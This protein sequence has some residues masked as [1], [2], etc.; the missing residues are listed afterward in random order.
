MPSALAYPMNS[1]KYNWGYHSDK[2]NYLNGRVLD[3]PRGKGLGGSSSINGMV[4]VRGHPDDFNQWEK[5]GA[6]GW[7]YSTC[8][9][10][11]LKAERWISGKDSYRSDNGNLHVCFGRNRNPLYKAFINSGI[12][13][14]YSYTSDY[15]GYKQEGFSQMQMTVKNGV[16]CSSYKAYIEGIVHRKNLKII[17]KTS[18]KELIIDDNKVTG[19]RVISK[20][21]FYEYFCSKEVIVSAGS[22]GSPTILQRSGIGDQKLLSELGVDLV[23]HLPGVGQNL[24]DHLEVYFQYKCKK[25]ITLNSKLNPLAKMLIGLE[26]FFLKKGL[27]ATNHFESCAFIRSKSGICSPDI[28]YHFL[29][30]AIR[31]DGK[32]AFKGHGFQ[33]H[34]GP[35]KPKSRGRVL[36]KS[37]NPQDPPSILF[38]YLSAQDDVLD[39]R[40]SIKLTKE[41]MSQPAMDS[42]R[43]EI[44]QPK[45]D[46][47]SDKEIDDWVK[48]NVES[49]YHPCG[50]CKMGDKADPE[51][52][53]D[54]QCRV[55]GI[56]NLRV[57]DSSIFPTIPNG[58]LNAPTIMVAERVS[59]MILDRRQEIAPEFY[60]WYPENW[61]NKQR[62]GQPCRETN[63]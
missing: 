10:Y 39:W 48:Q 52:V 24:Q 49:A 29:P 61:E 28:Q 16:R 7:N 21:R 6:K 38:N 46:F 23:K 44:I 2:E 26:W 57:I 53:V 50:T 31:Y 33:L 20:K 9:P 55:I 37:T 43:G 22:I 3:C 18:V 4:Y 5:S 45:I 41:I 59:D 30:A 62:E 63:F 42:F 25:R 34:V 17:T 58:N 36:I 32:L 8:L 60:V 47:S 35:N 19:V 54:D 1:K 15:N 27:G 51:S 11:F 56:K 13:A 12:E 14:G 40:T